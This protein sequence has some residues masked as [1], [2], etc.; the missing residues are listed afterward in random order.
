MT[1]NTI[2]RPPTALHTRP[3]R[4]ASSARYPDSLTV[5]TTVSVADVVLNA[6]MAEWVAAPATPILYYDAVEDVSAYNPNCP[7]LPLVPAEVTL[8]MSTAFVLIPVLMILFGF[9]AYGWCARP[10]QGSPLAPGF[11]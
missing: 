11:F 4:T 9:I 1:L 7:T 6:A 3:P 5:Y 2:R 8:V 10:F